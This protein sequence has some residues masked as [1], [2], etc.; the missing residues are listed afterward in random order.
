MLVESSPDPEQA[1]RFLTRL[2]RE[3]PA[4]FERIASSP[5]A[6]RYCISTFAYSH[7]LGEAI[8]RYPEWLPQIA[9]SGDLDRVLS[10]DQ[11]AVRLIEFLGPEADAPP[12]PL[13][14]ARFRRRMLVR[15]LLRDVLGMGELAEVTEELSNLSDAILEF[16]YQG[17]RKELAARHG[18]PLYVDLDGEARECG[19]AVISL[20]KLGGKELN[21]S[22]DIDLMFLYTAN[23]FTDGA[24]PLTNKEFFKKV[25]NRCIE[26]AF[27]VHAGRLLL[28]GGFG[29]R[30]PDGRSTARSR[31]S[32]S[33]GRGEYYKTRGRDWEP[34]DADQGAR[35]GRGPSSSRATYWT[36]SSR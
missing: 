18:T 9:T 8:L 22:S 16:A 15:I 13:A 34:A 33:T 17:I 10:A 23:G 4:A 32:L 26:P 1:H 36:S 7:F 25:A 21:Y 3:W 29:A 27:H 24:E 19:F 2:E 12:S 28:P 5:A 11:F 6:L 20:G 35:I 31:I 30:R 14:L